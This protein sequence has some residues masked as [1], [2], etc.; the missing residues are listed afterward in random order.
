V[1]QA[2]PKTPVKPTF[3]KSRDSQKQPETGGFVTAIVT[4]SQ[5]LLPKML[6]RIPGSLVLH[7][8]RMPLQERLEGEMVPEGLEHGQHLWS[9]NVL[10]EDVLGG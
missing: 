3:V 7:V 4:A 6:P 1:K 2:A 9:F 8:I 5:P 10:S